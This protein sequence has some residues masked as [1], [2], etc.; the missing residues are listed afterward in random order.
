MHPQKFGVIQFIFFGGSND[1][2]GTELYKRI[3]KYNGTSWSYYDSIPFNHVWGLETAIKGDSGICIWRMGLV[4]VKTLCLSF[5]YKNMDTISKRTKCICK[6]RPYSRIFRW[7][8]YAF[9]NGYAARY[10]PLTN[11][12]T[13]LATNGNSVSFSASTIYNGEIYISGWSNSLFYKYNP[14]TNHW[15]QLQDFPEFLSGGALR[16]IGNKIYIVGGS[17]GFSGGT[18][19]NIYEYNPLTNQWVLGGPIQF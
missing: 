17:S 11:S 3:Y 2:N 12:W 4:A 1:Y 18:S 5:K 16:A 9:Y 13:N 15:Q 8:S 7:I 10:D 6:L 14:V 19:W